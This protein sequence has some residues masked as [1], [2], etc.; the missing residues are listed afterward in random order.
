MKMSILHLR[1]P[2]GNQEK[3]SPHCN[4][5]MKEWM[6]RVLRV[7][8][9]CRSVRSVLF[10]TLCLALLSGLA[11]MVPYLMSDPR[12]KVRNLLVSNNPSIK[13]Y[14]ENKLI[15]S[16][17][18][19]DVQ[20]TK[21]LLKAGINPNLQDKYGQTSLYV[22]SKYGFHEIVD[23][24]LKAGANPNNGRPPLNAAAGAG[25]YKCV[26]SLLKAG[27]NPN[28]LDKYG[29]NPLSCAASR[30]AEID[31]LKTSETS[32]DYKRIVRALVKAGADPDGQVSS[33]G[34]TPLHVAASIN[35]V[36]CARSLL[37]A[38]AN[39]NIKDSEGKLP[40]DLATSEECKELLDAARNWVSLS[41]K[42]DSWAANRKSKKKTDFSKEDA[43]SILDSVGITQKEYAT[44]LRKASLNGDVK[45]VRLLIKAGANVNATGQGGETALHLA[46]SRN[47]IGCVQAL[48][49]AGAKVN[50]KDR[51]DRTPLHMLHQK[52]SEYG[53][54]LDHLECVKVLL[55]AGSDPNAIGNIG[56]A[57]ESINMA[58]SECVRAM[59]A[60]GANPN[61]QD[62]DTLAAP[63]H[64]AVIGNHWE[65]VVLLLAAGAD[66]NLVDGIR[67]ETPLHTA[68]WGG[69]GNGACVRLLLRS[70]ADPTVL[71]SYNNS[72]LDIALKLEY[73]NCIR[74]LLEYIKR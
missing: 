44:H 70:G 38:G 35:H 32:P 45:I 69:H 37:E 24:L 58:H 65:S 41:I 21:L 6:I 50:C 2:S 72:P 4:R 7:I 20:K 59:L 51:L 47:N 11:I 8:M 19:N 64:R 53:A 33:S 68:V 56:P 43:I 14:E 61:L 42:W 25:S 30:I 54:S 23:I 28:A 48:V 1:M 10:L 52:G 49:K 40:V 60:A 3:K 29:R 31:Q 62:P 9:T 13:W 57:L 74:I 67:G 16:L 55:E 71:N 27:A 63:L 46:A 12:T 34:K 39:P 66:P 17:W 36:E 15:K 26:K 5:S 73:V 18:I 22:A